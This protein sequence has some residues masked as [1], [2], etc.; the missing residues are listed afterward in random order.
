MGKSSSP[1]ESSTFPI[2]FILIAIFPYKFSKSFLNTFFYFPFKERTVWVIDS[3]LAIHGISKILIYRYTY[4]NILHIWPQNLL[5]LC[6]IIR[7]RNH[8]LWVFLCSW[9]RD[10]IWEKSI[11]R[12]QL[13]IGLRRNKRNCLSV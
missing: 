10:P 6:Q 4:P 13:G 5:L 12:C 8:V 7:L 11:G 1:F 2:S 9:P 3:A